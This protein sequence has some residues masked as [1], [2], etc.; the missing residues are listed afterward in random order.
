MPAA[1]QLPICVRHGTP[2]IHNKVLYNGQS[3][4]PSKFVNALGGVR[5]NAWPCIWVLF[6]DTKE[7]K[8]ADTLRTRVCA[9]M[10]AS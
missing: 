10:C 4:S 8:L 2:E 1:Y 5:R 7:W 6:P 3:H 9:R